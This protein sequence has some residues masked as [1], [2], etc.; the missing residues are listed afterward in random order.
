L[1]CYLTG[2]EEEV[3][4]MEKSTNALTNNIYEYFLDN[5][6]AKEVLLKED[7]STFVANKYKDKKY[8]SEIAYYEQTIMVT[9]RANASSS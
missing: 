6:K 5:A 8:F 3:V 1:K 9:I 2:T 4:V 7:L